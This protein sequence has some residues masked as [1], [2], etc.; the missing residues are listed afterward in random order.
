[1]YRLIKALSI[2]CI[3]L[4]ANFARAQVC[5]GTFG[6]PLINQTF[7]QGNNTDNWYGPLAQYAPGASTST[8]FKGPPGSIPTNLT[9]NQ[10]G[11]VK[12][13]ATP[14]NPY[15]IYWQPHADHTGDS[16]G[17]MLLIDGI[18]TKTV[19]FEQKMDDLCPNT[20]LR[21]SIWV[22]NTNSAAANAQPPNMILKVID[23]NG[24]LLGN[25]STGN[26]TADG[27][28]HQYTLDFSNANNST[29]TLQLVNDTPTNSGNDFA[30][31]DITVRA[32]GPGIAPFFNL[33]NTA[34]NMCEGN[35][36]SFTV[37][38][39]I[40]PE[41]ANPVYQ[42][43]ENK[44]T[45]WVDING[46][47][48]KQ[49]TINF[50]NQPAGTYQYRLITAINGNIDKVFC[51]A[52]SDPI[53]VTVNPLPVARAENFGPFCNGSTI[54]LNASG[55]TTYS[56]TGPNGF[57]SA[58]QSPTIINATKAMGGE[59]TVQV[60]ANGCTSPASTQVIVSD[61]LAIT[62][63]I[64]TAAIC[65]GKSIQL[66]ASGGTQY[67]WQPATG[68]SDPES[69]NPVASPIE[70]TVYSVTVTKDGCS[71][72]AQ[73]TVSVNKNAMADA[74]ADQK[75]V[76]GQK[77]TLNGKVS[78]DVT[79]LWTPADYLDDPTK[80]NPVASPPHDITYTLYATSNLGCSSSSDEVNITVYPKV[81]IPNT[82]SPNGDNVNDTWNIPAAASFPN[83]VV[84]IMNRYGNLVYQSTGPF[85]PWDGKMNGK[86]LPPAVYYYSVYLNE[87]F[88]TYTGWLMLVR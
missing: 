66:A 67:L 36:N 76:N 53:T 22:L 18:A 10:S 72:T 61:P 48:T 46:T 39:N 26:V 80:L 87:D 17:L 6:Q 25:A 73:I 37:N 57:T 50:I 7:G 70:T 23:P 49:A 62:T 54:Q 82:F 85:K 8:T 21:L 34:L 40:S 44:G 79:Y 32:C 19:F 78:S 74:G 88:Q 64:Q 3:L 1:M 83:P 58:A 84:K 28:W 71:G 2:V 27:M 4:F 9:A 52:V 31:D 55:G 65:E 68:L 63:N 14:G 29:V 59:Y 11:L 60:T 30:L 20:L 41:Y 81:V 75:I 33:N 47:T 15:S 16:N 56:W 12:T 45:G 5:T 43:Q 86:D 24:N 77:I 35:T 69:P 13:P 38:A 42:W 51:R